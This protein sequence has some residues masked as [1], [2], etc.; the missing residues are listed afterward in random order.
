[1]VHFNLLYNTFFNRK[2]HLYIFLQYCLCREAPY[3]I[4]PNFTPKLF[5]EENITPSNDWLIFQLSHKKNT[6]LLS[7]QY[8]LNSDKIIQ[9]Q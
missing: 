4:V 5:Q 2:I 1:M 8:W 3:K 7:S 6:P 9:G